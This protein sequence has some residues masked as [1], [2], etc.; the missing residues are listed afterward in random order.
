MGGNSSRYSDNRISSAAR[1]YGSRW[2]KARA[3]YLMRHPLCVMCER[4]GRETLASVV[5][6]I[7]PHKG[8]TSLFWDSDNW[9]P[10]CKPHHDST[11]QRIEA[12]GNFGC[13][14]SGRPLDAAHPWNR[15]A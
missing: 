4:E 2:Q 14:V 1:G 11:K 12:R 10:L 8:D 15:K 7:T 13:D 6:H 3:G 9:Q 5:D